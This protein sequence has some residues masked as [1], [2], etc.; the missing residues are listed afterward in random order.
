MHNLVKY[1]IQ[2]F[3][4]KLAFNSFQ[5]LRKRRKLRNFECVKFHT[6]QSLIIIII[7]N[8]YVVIGVQTHIAIH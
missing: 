4:A 3:Y 7:I 5:N 1:T 8:I 6:L 2:R